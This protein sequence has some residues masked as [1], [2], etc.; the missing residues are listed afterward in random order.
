MFLIIVTYVNVNDLP[1]IV[2][3]SKYV[4]NLR[5]FLLGQFVTEVPIR[6][7]LTINSLLTRVR[8]LIG[9]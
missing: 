3:S 4:I 7:A 9:S 5:P 6:W 2:R 1:K 8:F